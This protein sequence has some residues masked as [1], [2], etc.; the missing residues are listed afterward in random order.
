MPSSSQEP[1]KETLA[2]DIEAL[3]KRLGPVKVAMIEQWI[4]EVNGPLDAAIARYVDKDSLV[5][6]AGCS[7]GDPDLPSLQASRFTVGCDMDLP[8]LRANELADATVMA[9]LGRLPFPDNTFDVV[10]CKWVLEH[11]EHPEADFAECRRVLKPGGA[12]VALTPN[13]WSFFTLISRMIPY[14]LKQILKGNMFGLHEE[15]TFRTWYR[16]NSRG[17]LEALSAQ[18]GLRIERC[19]RLPGMWTFFIFFAPLARLVRRLEFVQMRVPGLRAAAT[20]LVVE[21]RKPVLPA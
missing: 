12:F 19:Q 8:G 13:A 7:R 10:V 20:Y 6:D 18:A 2:L 21:W 3:R 5:L 4:R 17:R 1:R 9:P 15:D 16:A 14:R 11:L